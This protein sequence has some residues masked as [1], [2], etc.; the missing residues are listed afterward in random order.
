MLARVKLAALCVVAGAYRTTDRR[1]TSSERQ[2]LI[3]VLIAQVLVTS[4]DIQVLMES[5]KF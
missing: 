3:V 4:L 2:V 5:T 1:P